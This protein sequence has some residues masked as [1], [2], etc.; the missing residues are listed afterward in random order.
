MAG[1]AAS[2]G[3]CDPTAAYPDFPLVTR[4]FNFT[5]LSVFVRLCVPMGNDKSPTS[6]HSD[7]LKP[8]VDRNQPIFVLNI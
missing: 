2:D 8:I 1:K 6:R 4:Q 3:E 5:N 7:V